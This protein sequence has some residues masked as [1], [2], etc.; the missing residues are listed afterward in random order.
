MVTLSATNPRLATTAGAG[1][2]DS[3]AAELCNPIGNVRPLVNVNCGRSLMLLESTPAAIG[4]PTDGSVELPC[5]VPPYDTLLA[6]STC[7]V[8]LLSTAADGSDATFGSSVSWV[9]VLA[10]P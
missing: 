2:F 9:G 5:D 7:S 10:T 6:Y 8:P 3:I 4:A 1:P